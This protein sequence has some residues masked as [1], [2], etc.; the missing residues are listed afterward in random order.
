LSELLSL[1]SSAANLNLSPQRKREKLFEALLAQLKSEAQRRPVLMVFE[2]AHWVDPTS[3]ELLDLTV[4]RVRRLPALL[5]ITSRPEFQPPWAGRSHDGVN[6]SAN[7]R[8]ALVPVGMPRHRRY[9]RRSSRA[10]TVHCLSRVTRRCWS[11]TRTGHRGAGDA[12]GVVDGSLD[13]LGP[14]AKEVAQIGAV[15]GRGLPMNS[16]A[17]GVRRE[18]SRVGPL[19]DA[20]RCFAAVAPHASYLF[21]CGAGRLTTLLRGRRRTCT[22]IAATLV[23]FRRPSSAGNCSLSPDGCRQ[24][25]GAR[26][27][28]G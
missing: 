2:D 19:S 3:R 6:G 21:A 27:I 11:A 7:G 4:E 25:P 23:R 22:R 9:C 12:T 26:S 18:G 14:V 5:V 10:P 8:Q 20:G 13:R 1:P 28:N 15:L 24:C 17:S 16:S